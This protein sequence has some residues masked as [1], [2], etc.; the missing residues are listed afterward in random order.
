MDVNEAENRISKYAQEGY[1]G[2]Q[3]KEIETALLNGVDIDPYLSKEY[4]ST[5]LTEIR[6]GLEAGLDVSSYAR[7]DYS[8][9]QMKEIRLGMMNRVDTE[10]YSSP[11][12]TWDQM[13]EIRIG[14]QQGLD[15]DEY[16]KMRFP[17]G[18]MRKKRIAMLDSR[19]RA[20]KEELA[21]QVHVEDFRIE[22]LAGAMEA[23]ITVLVDDMVITR[24]RLMDIL[25]ENDIYTGIQED[26]VE[27]IVEGT[28]GKE[29]LLIA[30]G[31]L[32][33][34]GDDGYYE[35]FFRTEVEKKPKILEDGSVDYQN[36]EWFETV[37]KG[38]RLAYY[39]RAEEGEDGYNV[40]GA[41]LKA[42][43]GFEK[44][45]LVGKGFELAPDKQ[46]YFALSDGMIKLDGNVMEVSKY[47][48]LDEITM[49]TGNIRFDGS[50][51]IRGNVENG[52]V[53]QATEDV[54][55]DGNV[56]AA[57]I[58]SGGN[59]LLKN[60]VNAAGHG[61]IKAE[62]GITSRF[63][64][65]VKVECAGDIMVNSSLNSQLY[66]KGMIT[67]NLTLAGGTAYAE[68]GF[69]L[70]N[71][72]NKAGLRTVLKLGGDIELMQQKKEVDDSIQDVQQEMQLLTGSY[73]DF[74][75]KYPPEVRNAMEVFIKIENALFTKEKQLNELNEIKE[76]I[77][78]YIRKA[79]N[80][81][82]VIA[83]QAFEGTVVDMNGS[84][85]NAANQFNI[86]VKRNENHIVALSGR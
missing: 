82:V 55:V 64:E 45:I 22:L 9:H 62:K 86:T 38:Q 80:A 79:N 74:K 54:I 21:R 83:G 81:K 7:I 44:S 42:R 6:R 12:Y 76:S 49:A 33:Q 18:E 26:A 59:I 57:T 72:G 23:Y 25:N 15:V 11:L 36:V 31:K 34:K 48:E 8:W 20:L 60:G 27:A 24:E 58:E 40:T 35:F 66:A 46:T 85:W 63:F 2:A 73:E 51:H 43:K 10:K 53:V 28:Y 68:G 77:D 65:T 37:K 75:E 67:S 16:R 13:R 50:I 56:G 3:L 19:K 78:I 69:K 70:Y 5:S 84:R 71:A 30:K 1:D 14:L 61:L 52:T 32:P 4:R 39:H 17:A 41:V 47:L 29:P